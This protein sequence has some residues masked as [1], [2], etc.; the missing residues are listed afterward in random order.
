MI[1][2]RESRRAFRE[3]RIL[4]PSPQVTHSPVRTEEKCTQ[5]SKTSVC[6]CETRGGSCQQCKWIK[7]LLKAQQRSEKMT[8]ERRASNVSRSKYAPDESES[9][10]PV[11]S[12]NLLKPVVYQEQLTVKK[13]SKKVSSQYNGPHSIYEVETKKSVHNLQNAEIVKTY[14]QEQSISPRI[15]NR[16]ASRQNSIRSTHKPSYNQITSVIVHQ[17][18]STTKENKYTQSNIIPSAKDEQTN[19]SQLE[20]KKSRPRRRSSQEEVAIQ[21]IDYEKTR[22]QKI[23]E[24]S[25]EQVTKSDAY[26]PGIPTIYV[27]DTA[28]SDNSKRPPSSLSSPAPCKQTQYSNDRR[29]A[30]AHKS[31]LDDAICVHCLKQWKKYQSTKRYNLI[32]IKFTCGPLLSFILFHSSPDNEVAPPKTNEKRNGLDPE[33][34]FRER[35]SQA[36]QIRQASALFHYI[37]PRSNTSPP[38][39]QLNSPTSAQPQKPNSHRLVVT[40]QNIR[41]SS[42]SEPPKVLCTCKENVDPGCKMHGTKSKLTSLPASAS[43]RG[44]NF[45]QTTHATQTKVKKDRYKTSP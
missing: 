19:T 45:P 24:V 18:P 38:T 43:R 32:I 42:R 33:P 2:R 41:S 21:V 26:N 30:C 7:Y 36:T 15:S 34:S 8:R 9:S 22:L 44:R 40:K 6:N 17:E 31:P 37:S 11:S 20:I 23:S 13:P 39:S 5:S 4:Y 14:I 28:D 27:S 35:V 3:E 25:M 16:Q 10:S 1:Q 29:C 12:G